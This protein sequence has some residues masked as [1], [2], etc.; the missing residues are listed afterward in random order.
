MNRRDRHPGAARRATHAVLAAILFFAAGCN[1]PDRGALKPGD[2]FATEV[3]TEWRYLG[4][5]NEF[6]TYSAAVTHREGNLFQLVVFSGADIAHVYEIRPDRVVRRLRSGE[7]EFREQS[8]LGGPF[9]EEYTVLE[10]PLEA[11]R[12]WAATAVFPNGTSVERRRIEGV[13]LTLDTPAGR[14]ENV[15]LVRVSYESGNDGLEYYAP[16]VG[17]VRSEYL[18]LEPVISELEAFTRGK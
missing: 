13:G 5:G 4:H 17:L 14:F 8:F 9:L 7:L 11:G 1:G 18:G 16:G 10:A 12:E 6:A 15:I 2:F 3:G